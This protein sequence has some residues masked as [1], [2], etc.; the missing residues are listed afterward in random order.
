[1]SAADVR[2]AV[3]MLRAAL[4]VLDPP[5]PKTRAPRQTPATSPGLAATSP[6]EDA[7]AVLD[8]LRASADPDGTYRRGLR[9]LEGSVAGIPRYRVRKALALL[10]ATGLSGRPDVRE[11]PGP[12]GRVDFALATA[13]DDDEE[14]ADPA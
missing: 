7:A 11:T 13:S 5:A 6:E 10:T 3:L 1:M 8:A 14:S 4:D 9:A 2:A 12:R